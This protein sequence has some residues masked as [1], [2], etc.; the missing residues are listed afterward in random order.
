LSEANTRAPSSKEELPEH[1][2]S[3]S[4]AFFPGW[5]MLGFAAAAQFMSAPGQSFSVAAFKEPMRDGL[6]ASETQFSLAYGVA[7]IASGLALPFIGR[8][9]DRLGARLLLPAIALLLGAAC[10][11]MSTVE[12]LIG[13]YI[14]FLLIRP[15]GQGALTLV[16]TWLVGEWFERRRG[17]ATAIS[18]MGGSLSVMMIPLLN[19][20]L[21]T[22]YDWRTAWFV[23]GVL[24]WASLVLPGWIFIRDRP[25]DL[26]LQP[27]GLDRH[28]PRMKK[29]NHSDSWHVSEVIRDPTFWKLLAVPATSGMVG[30]GLI[31]HQV[32][33]LGSRGVEPAWAL[34]LISFQAIVATLAVLG[35]GWLT[36]HYSNRHLLAA[37]MLMLATATGLVL[38]LPRPEF[39]IFYSAL[40]GLH[41][42]IM[43]STGTVVWLN[44]YG[45]ANQGAVRGVAFAVMILAAAIGPLPFALVI[46]SVNSYDPALIAFAIVPLLAAAL[47][48]S[49]R[50]PRVAATQ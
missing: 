44:Y 49:A 4:H 43:R 48:M 10:V 8:M 21:I 33:L 23:L 26:G 16:G 40:L 9:V 46:D 7:T 42:A 34:G 14:A 47:V 35:A 5:T 39:A 36:D 41:G 27:D 24:V 50:P 32:S 29:A 20:W 13:L 11:Y 2:S 6:G 3:P 25:E 38:F 15:L 30:T 22:D 45:R 18:G 19:G 17:F 28:D 12:T 31:F 37:A 1:D